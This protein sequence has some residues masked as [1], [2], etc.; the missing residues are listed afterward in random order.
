MAAIRLR[1]PVSEADARRLKMNDHLFLSGLLITARDM[2]HQRAL[3]Y[4][5]E[6]K[7]LPFSFKNAALFHCGPIVDKKGSKWSVVAAGPTTSIRM[8]PMEP[9]FIRNFGTR[10]I[11]GKGG[12]GPKT[13]QALKEVGGVYCVFTGG[14]AVL[15]AKAVKAVK[16]VAWLDLGMAEALWMLEVEEFGPLVVAIDSEGNNLHA[17]LAALVESRRPEIYKA[18][19]L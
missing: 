19:R 6:E 5:R 14:A 10:I 4:L 12:M 1:T 9:A 11:I 15:A 2:A 8:E 3:Q 18:L 13:A 7:P 16:D 17:G